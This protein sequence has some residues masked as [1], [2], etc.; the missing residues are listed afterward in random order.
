[1]SF[2]VT[3]PS[4]SESTNTNNTT[5]N[6]TTNL[7]EPILLNGEYEVALVEAIYNLSWFLPVGSILYKFENSPVEIIPLV[8]HDGDSITQVLNKVNI[9]IQEHVL[10]KKYNE[11]YNLYKENEIRAFN[12]K[13]NPSFVKVILSNSK[14]PSSLY[15]TVN[16][17]NVI[18][19]IKATETEY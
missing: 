18:N 16:N 11:R 7:N 8:F 9:Q 14:F 10:I 15:G 19:D 13:D 4:N 1:M 12:N 2:Y 17:N 3:L 6:Y 5:T